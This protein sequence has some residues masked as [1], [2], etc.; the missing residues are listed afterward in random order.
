VRPEE[1]AER[2]QR[3]RCPALLIAGDPQRGALVTA[4]D[5]DEM[6]VFLPHLKT[7]H[8]PGAGHSIRRDQFARYMQV[9]QDA[10]RRRDAP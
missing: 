5:I 4:E 2:L 3:I 7:A 1:V 8:I 10:L 6:R 9:V